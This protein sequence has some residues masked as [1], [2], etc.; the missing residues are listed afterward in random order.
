MCPDMLNFSAFKKKICIYGIYFLLV[1]QVLSIISFSACE[2]HESNTGSRREVSAYSELTIPVVSSCNLDVECDYGNFEFY[3]W[4]KKEV[5]FEITYKVRG[6]RTKVELDKILKKFGTT[7][8]EES[9]VI[10]FICSYKGP[11]GK[12]EDTFSVVK[13][14]MPGRTSSVECALKQ[15]KLNFLD[16]LD[17]DLKIDVGKA[18]VEIN[19]LKGGIRYNGKSANLRI[20]SGVLKNN[21]SIIT[22]TGNIRIKSFFENPGSFAFNTGTGIIELTI[23]LDL[24]AVFESNGRID[25]VQAVSSDAVSTFLV[26]CGLGKI[27]INRF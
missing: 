22:S 26:K 9:G 17:C 27:N 19:R 15:G 20:S 25:S 11:E 6:S 10:K 13:I 8:Y 18:E 1:M 4:D 3:N 7:V 5:K 16:D 24:N 21:S 14:F 12:Y 2:K 23:P